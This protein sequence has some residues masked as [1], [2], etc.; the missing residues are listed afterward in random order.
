MKDLL[1]IQEIE[2]AISSVFGEIDG[3]NPFRDLQ[4]TMQRMIA[5]NSTIYDPGKD[6]DEQEFGEI[7]DQE[8]DYEERASRLMGDMV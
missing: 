7:L 3:S 5:W 4:F 8:G 6:I 2:K 1:M